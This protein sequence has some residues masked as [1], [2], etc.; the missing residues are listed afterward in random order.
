MREQWF[1]ARAAVYARLHERYASAAPEL[2]YEI[3]G[4]VLTGERC[5]HG[6]PDQGDGCIYCS[7][8][9]ADTV[10][11]YP[12]NMQK[13]PMCGHRRFDFMSATYAACER[14]QCGYQWSA[15]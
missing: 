6:F 5:P 8:G 15:S 14:R 7:N 2:R 1:A 10:K 3:V 4:E 12:G 13:C 11:P 9:I